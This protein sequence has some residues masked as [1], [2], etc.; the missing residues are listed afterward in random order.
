M[1]LRGLNVSAS[2][3]TSN[4]TPIV[5]ALK[6]SIKQRVQFWNSTDFSLLREIVSLASWKFDWPRFVAVLLDAFLWSVGVEIQRTPASFVVAIGGIETDAG[7][8]CRPASYVVERPAMCLL[9]RARK[10][11][12]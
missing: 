6:H 10:F 12:L 4:G 1:F 2:L 8:V 7:L 5:L 9:A 3:C 11:A